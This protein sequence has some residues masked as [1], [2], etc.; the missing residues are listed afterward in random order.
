MKNVSPH[1]SNN[2]KDGFQ[3]E[4]IATPTPD[5]NQIKFQLCI[6]DLPVPARRYVSD[7]CFFKSEEHFVKIFF[8]EERFTS[9]EARSCIQI[10]IRNEAIRDFIA[11]MSER[12]RVIA[13]QDIVPLDL[14]NFKSEP[15]QYVK[16]VSNVLFISS[17][18]SE[19]CID[20]YHISPFNKNAFKNNVNFNL[21]V[22]PIVRVDLETRD[23]ERLLKSLC[24]LVNNNLE[25]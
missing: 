3:I 24:N 5:Q 6:D 4:A 18:G 19:A 12:E 7:Y 25:K 13:S 1:K 15:D 2:R 14:P 8:C 16:L 22:E 17:E 20:F 21:G 11:E 10:K 9:N 23:L